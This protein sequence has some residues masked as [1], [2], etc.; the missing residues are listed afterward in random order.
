MLCVAHMRVVAGGED[1]STKK[2]G[3]IREIPSKRISGVGAWSAYDVQV[4]NASAP[5]PI[6]FVVRS[7]AVVESVVS[8]KR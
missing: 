8:S 1:E 5:S 6:S 7:S 2:E 4:D 3:E